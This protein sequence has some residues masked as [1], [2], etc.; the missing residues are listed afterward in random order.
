[1]VSLGQGRVGFNS[2]RAEVWDGSTWSFAS[3]GEHTLSEPRHLMGSAVI[4]V[5]DGSDTRT[6][7]FFVGGVSNTGDS[8]MVD[9]F[10]FDEHRVLPR[11][12]A[13]TVR[14]PT[15]G[16]SFSREVAAFVGSTGE[17]DIFDGRT[18]CWTSY[19]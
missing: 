15:Q 18:L 16:V 11:I 9:M 3:W 8:S 12:N 4:E 2:D 17:I 19:K 13:P 6:V 5:Y 14:G 10:D 7:G 1:K